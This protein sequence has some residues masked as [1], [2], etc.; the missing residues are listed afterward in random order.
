MKQMAE[1]TQPDIWK[2]YLQPGICFVTKE[3]HDGISVDYK[4]TM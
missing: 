1:I 2:M 3:I 4:R